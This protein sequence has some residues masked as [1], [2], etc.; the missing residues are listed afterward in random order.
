[1]NGFEVGN[2]SIAGQATAEARNYSEVEPISGIARGKVVAVE[3]GDGNGY[4]IG[5]LDEND[6]VTRIHSHVMPPEGV[7]L[8]VG[9]LVSLKT[10]ERSGL[11]VILSSGGAGG[12]SR[13]VT[14]WGT[15][16]DG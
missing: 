9:D 3:D 16:F 7:S 13:A 6:L 8:G 4:Q 11:P 12:C 1:M 14:D 5:E 2:R 10:D 15:T